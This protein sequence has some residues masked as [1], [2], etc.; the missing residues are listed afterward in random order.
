MKLAK[1]ALTIAKKEA[2]RQVL[3]SALY[4]L[5]QVHLMLGNFKDALKN[6]DE[7]QMC[8]QETND[9]RSEANT[10]ALQANVMFHSDDFNEARMKA[11]EAVYLFQK[12]N[13]A[14]GEEQGWQVIDDI[15]K[16]EAERRE[17]EQ[18]QQL[19]QWQQQAWMQSQQQQAGLVFQ[20]IH[21]QQKEEAAPE[22]SEAHGGYQAKLQKLDLG[23]VLEMSVVKTQILEI[24]KGVIGYDDDIE[25]D[26]PLMEAGLTSNTAVLLRDSLS[27]QLPG[28]P[29][30]VTLIFDYPSI[31]S[32]ADLIVE[33][34]E[35]IAQKKAKAALK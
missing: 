30:P 13:D 33:S 29:L 11:E 28:I 34:S 9:E 19:L 35:K 8:F 1:E 24:T 10:L 16:G 17:A 3:G 4:A 27:Q 6:S 2:D 26:V 23:G 5:T 25:A 15:E 14:R 7:A 21:H 12:L 20:P 22:T 31:G 32:M 18:Q